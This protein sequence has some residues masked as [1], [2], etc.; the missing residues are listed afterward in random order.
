MMLVDSHCHLDF[1]DFEGEHEALIARAKAAGVTKMVTICT[2]LEAFETVHALT[3]HEAVYMA[4]GI[5]P[6]E[7]EPH[8]LTNGEELIALTKRPKVVGIGE[9]GLDFFYDKSPR[10]RQEESFRVHC[11]VSRETGL[12]IIIHTRDGEADTVRILQDEMGQGAFTGEIHCFTGSGYL[13]DACLELGLYI[14]ASGITTFKKSEELRETFAA[15]PIDRV[16][17]ETDAPYLAPT[18]FRGRRNEPAYTAHTAAVMAG[19]FGLSVDD[20]AAQT[21]ANFHRLFTRVPA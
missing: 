11:Q 2:T 1:P 19:V 20:F 7:A 17:V 6:H 9:T 14:S 15:V 3:A 21:T 5:H 10:V 4:V 18:P 12:P 16:L 13:R 8:G